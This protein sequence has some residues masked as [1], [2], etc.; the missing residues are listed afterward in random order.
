[1]HI[2]I[3]LIMPN[4]PNFLRM[5]MPRK[6]GADK[7]DPPAISVADLTDDQLEEFADEYRK[8]FIEH[9]KGKRKEANAEVLRPIAGK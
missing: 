2:D 4:H 6:P 9:A 1:M 3:K 7:F 5:D 8:S